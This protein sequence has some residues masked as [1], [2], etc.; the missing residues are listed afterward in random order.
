MPKDPYI[1]EKFTR[2]N[3]AAREQA[4]EYF[5]RYPK[6]QY[7]GRDPARNPTRADWI[8]RGGMS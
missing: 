6:D 1:R 8:G 4:R 3:I 7:G 5:A 2:N